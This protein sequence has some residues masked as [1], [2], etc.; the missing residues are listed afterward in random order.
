[1]HKLPVCCGVLLRAPLVFVAKMSV[2]PPF[3]PVVQLLLPQSTDYHL[4]S[5]LLY[6]MHAS[7]TSVMGRLPLTSS[8]VP[9]YTTPASYMV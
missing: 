6:S 7:N 5:V 9:G 4:K 2:Q 1:M 8:D 3:E